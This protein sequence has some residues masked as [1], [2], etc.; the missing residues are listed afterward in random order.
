M[1]S[2][3]RPWRR[4]MCRNSFPK[5]AAVAGRSSGLLAIAC[6]MAAPTSSGIS[7]LSSAVVRL[8]G[9]PQELGDD[10]LAA[11]AFEGGVTGE[12]AKQGGAQAVHVGGGVGL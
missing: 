12:R 8:G 10:L 6:S 7:T 11:A 3:V 2:T 4:W 9:D 5:S 1:S